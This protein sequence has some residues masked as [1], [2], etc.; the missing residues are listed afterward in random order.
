MT[1]QQ[2]WAHICTTHNRLKLFRA[3]LASDAAAAVS[4]P[5]SLAAQASGGPRADDRHTRLDDRRE[6][7]LVEPGQDLEQDEDRVRRVVDP[8]G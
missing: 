1:A 4:P 7:G 8:Q 3:R 2:E 5:S 6:R